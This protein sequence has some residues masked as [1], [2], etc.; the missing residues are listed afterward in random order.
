MSAEAR[1]NPED[2]PGVGEVPPPP[3][4]DNGGGAQHD[5]RY[6]PPFGEANPQPKQELGLIWHGDGNGRDHIGDWLVDDM[7]PATG[8][9]LVS[10]QWGTY[11]TFVVL[12]LAGSV[13]TMTS[14]A[15]RTVRRQGGS[16]WLAAEGQAQVPIRLDGLAREKV[17]KAERGGDVKPIDPERMPF[18]WRKSCPSLADDDARRDLRQLIAAA[19]KDMREKFDLEL[20]L[21]VIDALTS[22]ANFRD[23]NDASETQRVFGMLASLA[24]EFGLL[25]VVIDHF[26]K[27]AETGTRNSSVKEDAAEAVL[28]MLGEKEITGKVTN[29]RMALRKVRGGPTG[30]E[31][32][33]KPRL[34]ELGQREDGKPVTTFVIDWDRERSADDFIAAALDLNRRR[35]P[36]E[37]LMTFMRALDEALCSCGKKMRPRVD[38]PEILAVDREIVRKEFLKAYPA[39]NRKSKDQAFR[40][41]EK[42]ALATNFVGHREVG[43]VSFFWRL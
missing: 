31:I 15:G 6:P 11:K 34:V 43:D 8:V 1:G 28:A 13:M 41:C 20:V 39:E 9:A 32:A 24:A 38:S 23:A 17:A 5:E 40:R 10:G 36:P 18:V 16:L 35:P 21:V 29:P 14:F 7:L 42:K 37:S 4:R 3:H 33:V 25:I 27:K 22:A 26:G 30:D 19:A 12:D 2:W